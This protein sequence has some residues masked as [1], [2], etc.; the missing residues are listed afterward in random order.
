[1]TS[2]SFN[3]HSLLLCSRTT[4]LTD[5]SLTIF[6]HSLIMFR[7]VLYV[8]FVIFAFEQF[9]PVVG[10]SMRCQTTSDCT[11]TWK[12]YRSAVECRGG[13]CRCTGI[14]DEY[15]TPG[16]FTCSVPLWLSIGVPVVA[17]V[18]FLACVGSLV[19]YCIQRRRRDE[20]WRRLTI[21]VQSRQQ[22]DQYQFQPQQNWW[23]ITANLLIVTISNPHWLE[24]LSNKYL[25]S[26]SSCRLHQPANV[27]LP[28][29][30]IN[31]AW[32]RAQ[33]CTHSHKAH[34]A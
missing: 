32:L 14:Y 25:N 11:A 29:S 1:M 31:D 16:T 27:S 17:G 4:F 15:I 8:I 5:H 2:Q 18:L 20:I 6:R 13:E 19:Y 30:W 3:S 33:A 28:L 23:P 21:S 7:H 10:D 34:N 26:E 9:H 12:G 22:Q 24:W